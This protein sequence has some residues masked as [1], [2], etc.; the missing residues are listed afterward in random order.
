M[1]VEKKE[2]PKKSTA[3]KEATK[4]VTEQ[5]T[6]SKDQAPAKSNTKPPVEDEDL[7]CV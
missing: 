5:P 3:T 7:V 6:T 2:E 4:K 1:V